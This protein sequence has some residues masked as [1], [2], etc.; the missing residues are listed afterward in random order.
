MREV[1]MYRTSISIRVGDARL[2]RCFAP[3]NQPARRHVAPSACD[4]QVVGQFARR[5]AGRLSLLPSF[6]PSFRPLVTR[7]FPQQPR[8]LRQ[9]LL[10]FTAKYQRPLQASCNL[11]CAQA[12]SAC[13]PR[14]G[15][16]RLSLLTT[17]QVD[18]D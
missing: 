10:F 9:F 1:V 14:R 18:S 12:N 11:T 5:P 16:N 17:E 4:G 7:S 6:R 13:Y 15:G 2:V 3:I 8:H